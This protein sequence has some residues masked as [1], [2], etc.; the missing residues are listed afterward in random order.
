MSSIYYKKYHLLSDLSVKFIL[1]PSLIMMIYFFNKEAPNYNAIFILF[2]IILCV[3]FP[4]IFIYNFKYKYSFITQDETKSKNRTQISNRD[5]IKLILAFIVVFTYI[6]SL[7]NE[8]IPRVWV[9]YLFIGIIAVLYIIWIT[10]YITKF[11]VYLVN[12]SSNE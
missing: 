12:Y 10:N 8:I 5:V 3:S 9:I 1:I 7:V 2:A 4:P 6:I 11:I